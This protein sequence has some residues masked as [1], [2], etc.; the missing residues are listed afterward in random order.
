MLVFNSPK[1]NTP[2]PAGELGGGR[3]T[4]HFYCFFAYILKTIC[5]TKKY[6][7]YIKKIDAYKFCNRFG[8]NIFFVI[9]HIF[10]NICSRG[11]L[12]TEKSLFFIVLTFL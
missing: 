10:R 5:Y 3:T 4:G 9:F 6:N 2:L 7:I 12:I 11:S 8:H 1:I